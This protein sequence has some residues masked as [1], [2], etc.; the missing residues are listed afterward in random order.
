MPPKCKFTKQEVIAAALEITRQSG[1]AAL[2]ARALGAMLGTSPKPIFSLFHS[3]EEVRLAVLDTAMERYHQYLQQDM[4]VGT[5][6]AYKASG[7]AYIRFA[8]EE[9]ELF[10][11]LFMRDRSQEVISD[12]TSE[13][14]PLLAL[15]QE[16]LSLSP[17]QARI[18]HLEMWIYVHGF[19]TMAATGY[20]PWETETIS[21]MLTDAFQGL[22]LYYTK[23][24]DFHGRHSD[25][26]ADKNLS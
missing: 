9:P 19:A 6:P 22:C 21:S 20:L 10:K 14:A 18:F 2:T 16:K 15:I 3:M 11:L 13:I 17:E 1:A 23:K 24:E 26:S 4:S 25:Q 8:R 12:D 5:Y 7:L